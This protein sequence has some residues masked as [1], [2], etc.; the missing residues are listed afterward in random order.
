VKKFL[1]Q[2]QYGLLLLLILSSDVCFAQRIDLLIPAY[3]NP[4][5]EPGNAMWATLLESAQSNQDVRLHVI[6]NPDNGPGLNVDANYLSA[7]GTGPLPS[8]KQAGAIIYGY[9]ATNFATKSMDEVKA[10]I[11]AYFDNFYVGQIDGVFLDEMSNNLAFSSYYRQINDYV[12]SKIAL[13]SVI[14]NPGIATTINPDQQSVFSVSD[15]IDS[16]DVLVTFEGS[17]DGYAVNDSSARLLATLPAQ[18][19]ANII[20]ATPQWDNAIATLIDEHKVGLVFVTSDVL[21]NP[22]DQL[23]EY[24]STML[25]AIAAGNHRIKLSPTALFDRRGISSDFSVM[26]LTTEQRPII[27]FD[28]P[29]LEGADQPQLLGFSMTRSGYRGNFSF[30]LP[31]QIDGSSIDSLSI[32]TSYAGAEKA[33]QLWQWRLYNFKKQRWIDIGDNSDAVAGQWNHLSF[34]VVNAVSH[35][36][37]DDNALRVRYQTHTDFAASQLDL[38]Q[39]QLTQNLATPSN[40][41]SWWQPVPGTSWQW[42]LNS[43]DI[44]TSVDAEMY[45]VDLFDTSQQ[46]IADL[47]SDA[48]T[49][50]CY[51]SAGSYENWRA[52][53]NSF[54]EDVQGNALEDWI[55]ERWLDIRNIDQLAPIMTARM[56]LAVSKGCDGVEPDNVDAYTNNSGFDLSAEHQLTYNRWLAEQA[57]QRGL[58]IGLKNDLDQVVDLV[59]DFDWAL[60]EQCFQFNECTKLIPFVRAGKAVFGVE[61]VGDPLDFCQDAKRMKFSWLRKRRDL[62]SFRIPCLPL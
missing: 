13:A 27:N 8:L 48:R 38:L 3:A 47:H 5:C 1:R 45:D 19:N 26:A 55:G 4:C 46:T 35:F 15:Y 23:P 30:S 44:D 2:S 54:P 59:D 31:D 58:S 11:D 37:D 7:D 12:K 61:Y 20:Y 49:V 10:D 21:N 51:F 41:N 60:N 52:D 43:G 29:F 16:V 17:F 50:I 62:G 42:Q 34:P 39:I 53:A 24:W 40:T 32:E 56:D 9:V 57:H 25:T 18:N 28:D 14:G 22:Y 6:F 33:D 36:V